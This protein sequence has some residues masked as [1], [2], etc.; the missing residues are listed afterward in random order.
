MFVIFAITAFLIL[1]YF[2]YP[3]WLSLLRPGH[4]GERSETTD[5]NGVTLILLSYNGQ[6]YLEDKINFLLKELSVFSIMK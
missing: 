3:V 5:A 4:A 6:Q 1:L 2:L